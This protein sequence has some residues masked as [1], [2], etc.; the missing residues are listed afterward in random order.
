M[1]IKIHLSDHTPIKSP[2]IKHINGGQRI[3]I[4]ALGDLSKEH[5]VDLDTSVALSVTLNTLCVE[6]YPKKFMYAY[7]HIRINTFHVLNK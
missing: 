3:A 1:G 2:I 4:K 6:Q 5:Y 7:N